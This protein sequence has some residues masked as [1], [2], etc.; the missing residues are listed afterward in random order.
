MSGED[1]ET[2][3]VRRERK[4]RKRRERI[5]QHGKN[6]AKV[7]VDAILKRLRGRGK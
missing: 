2:R 3:Q 4:L 6:M 7:Y 1:I 5:P